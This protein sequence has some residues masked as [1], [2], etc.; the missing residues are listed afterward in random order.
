MRFEDLELFSIYVNNSGDIE[1]APIVLSPNRM[2]C[3]ALDQRFKLSEKW[4]LWNLNKSEWKHSSIEE[5]TEEG[6]L[7][8]I[9]NNHEIVEHV[10]ELKW[11]N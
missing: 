6:F 3:L 5:N 4:K 1:F 10:F 11:I 9:F 2:V 7:E 8:D